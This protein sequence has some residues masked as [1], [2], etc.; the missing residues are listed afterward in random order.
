MASY[1]SRPWYTPSCSLWVLNFRTGEKTMCRQ[2]SQLRPGSLSSALVMPFVLLHLQ[3]QRGQPQSDCASTPHGEVWNRG[4]LE[5]S[6]VVHATPS[7]GPQ[8]VSIPGSAEV[9][10]I[11]PG[12][13]GLTCMPKARIE[14]S[15]SLCRS[16]HLR[17]FLQGNWRQREN[18]AT[19]SESLKAARQ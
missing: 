2:N 13:W 8:S 9:E 3:G 19:S 18:L 17:S 6:H 5:V 11:S 10:R 16:T 1:I 14:R 4:K 15:T 12:A 7:V